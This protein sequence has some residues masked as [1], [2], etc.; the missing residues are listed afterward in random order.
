MRAPETHLIHT[1]AGARSTHL[2]IC[3]KRAECGVIL[4]EMGSLLGATRVIDHDDV[5]ERVPT[6]VPA[7]EELAT[8]S[9]KPI[10]G[11]LELLL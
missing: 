5:Q 9:A 8:N 10:D 1:Q 11:H 4:E 7:T 6:A 2:D 3:I